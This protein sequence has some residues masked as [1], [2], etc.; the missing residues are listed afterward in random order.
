[1]TV[2]PVVTETTYALAGVNLGPFAT[3][4]PYATESEVQVWLT[5]GAGVASVQLGAGDFTIAGGTPLVNGGNVTVSAAQL[6]LA[7]GAWPAGYTVT[8]VR[9]SAMGQTAALGEAIGFSPKSMEDAL[10]FEERQIQDSRG[11]LARA[12]SRGPGVGT[13][14]AAG[15]SLITGLGTSQTDMTA[16]TPLAQVLAIFASAGAFVS[17]QQVVGSIAA[18]RLLAAAPSSVIFVASYAT[19]GDGGEG[20]FQ[21]VPTD[22]ASADDGGSII[23]AAGVP[24]RFKRVTGGVMRPEWFGAKLDGVTNDTPAFQAALNAAHL[25]KIATV[26]HSRGTAYLATELDI[27]GGVV[28][29]SGLGL[30]APRDAQHVVNYGYGGVIS[31]NPAATIALAGPGAGISGFCIMAHGIV[32][33]AN[34]AAVATWTG[35]A[36]TIGGSNAGCTVRDN[37][38]VGF[39][40]AILSGGSTE[41]L[42]ILNNAIDCINGVLVTDSHDTSR[43]ENIQGYCY[44]SI[45]IGGGFPATADIKRPGIFIGLTS[46]EFT[47]VRNCFA[48]GWKYSYWDANG[49]ADTWVGCQSDNDPASRVDTPIGFNILG[50]CH[51]IGIHACSS[52]AGSIGIQAQT[53]DLE[54]TGYRCWNLDTCG[55]NNLG[56]TLV[57]TGSYFE[58]MPT[59]LINVSAGGFTFDTNHLSDVYGQAI[60]SNTGPALIGPGNICD[61][62]CGT[63]TI[64]TI[65][66]IASANAMAV[67]FTGT[68]FSVT[69]VTDIFAMT[70][71]YWVGREITLFAAGAFTVHHNGNAGTVSNVLLNGA[72]NYAMA[73]GN[74]LTLR[75]NG[76]TWVEIGRATA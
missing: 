35:N 27:P 42:L 32:I 52:S 36:I 3:V 20:L 22:V 49:S 76:T 62:G 13:P 5:K 37:Y 66:S 71:A 50:V 14:Y 51:Y 10:D 45:G 17:S 4:F 23:A 34:A 9:A 26:V 56:A 2:A 57:C 46:C 29:T 60:T 11:S 63:F 73:A 68:T 72:A 67:P 18:L 54:V 58:N 38:I 59:A 53:T 21:Y 25:A 74:T 75:H 31:L 44:A 48:Y 47:Q 55:I 65:Q 19:P 28:L 61:G 7:G 16:A 12:L 24:G 69:G 6:A 39:N 15:G 64:A 43:I 1:M 41:K 33:P 70:S 30:R 40:V 8:M